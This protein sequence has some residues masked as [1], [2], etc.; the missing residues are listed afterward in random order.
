MV[1]SDCKTRDDKL[2]MPRARMHTVGRLFASWV[3]TLPS[4]AIIMFRSEFFQFLPSTP[5]VGLPGGINI[6]RSCVRHVV[7]PGMDCQSSD[8]GQLCVLC[9]NQRSISEFICRVIGFSVYI[10]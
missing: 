10:S 5:D 1:V 6:L 3:G 7:R 8:V 9:G 4:V 2:C